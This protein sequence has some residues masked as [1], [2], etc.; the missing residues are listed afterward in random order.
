L[1]KAWDISRNAAEQ[2]CLCSIACVILWTRR[3]VCCIV[4]CRDRKPNWWLGIRLLFAISGRR[5]ERSNFS[6]TLDTRGRRLIGLYMKSTSRFLDC[7]TCR[8]LL[9]VMFPHILM[10]TYIYMRVTILKH[11]STFWP[12]SNIVHVTWLTCSLPHIRQCL[13]VGVIYSLPTVCILVQCSCYY[14]ALIRVLRY[15]G[16]KT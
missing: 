4:E 14:L 9:C 11:V 12:S 8:L 2:Y 15:W 5:R 13:Y 10:Y 7:D 3:C 6:N 16:I 1:S